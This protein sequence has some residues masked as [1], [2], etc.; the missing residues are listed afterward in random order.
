MLNKQ[1]DELA[2][3]YHNSL[4]CQD[5]RDAP[6][7]AWSKLP[8]MAPYEGK[9]HPKKHLNHFNDLIELHQVSDLVKCHCFAVTLTKEAKKWFR[10]LELG[11]ILAWSQFTIAFLLQ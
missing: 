11:S 3:G 5:I 4:F 2:A 1:E 6:L 7:P 8:A 9:M 10:M